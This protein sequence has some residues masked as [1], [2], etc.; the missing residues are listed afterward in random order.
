MDPIDTTISDVAYFFAAWAMLSALSVL[1]IG[2]WV[3]RR[4][5]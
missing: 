3:W 4:L 5:D 1:G 2:L